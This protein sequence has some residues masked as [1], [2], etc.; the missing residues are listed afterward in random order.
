MAIHDLGF[1]AAHPQTAHRK[2]GVTV[3]F[4][5]PGLLQQSERGTTGTE[6][7]KAGRNRALDTGGLVLDNDLPATLG[8]PR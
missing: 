5:D 1:V 3:G 7:H 2:A 4:R 8:A 6:K